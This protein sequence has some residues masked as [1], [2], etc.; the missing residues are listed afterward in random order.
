MANP[1]TVTSSTKNTQNQTVI[2]T[3]DGKH[4][5]EVNSQANPGDIKDGTTGSSTLGSAPSS[6]AD[7]FTKMLN[8]PFIIAILTFFG[9]DPKT[10]KQPAAAASGQSSTT[11][12]TPSKQVAST[13]PPPPPPPQAPANASTS[14]SSSTSAAPKK[15]AEDKNAL[16]LLSDRSSVSPEAK[17]KGV[18]NRDGLRAVADLDINDDKAWGEIKK[19][20]RQRYKDEANKM[21]NDP[22]ALL[23]METGTVTITQDHFKEY[24]TTGAVKPAP[25]SPGSAVPPQPTSQE[26]ADCMGQSNAEQAATKAK[27]KESSSSSSST[28]TSSSSST[29]TDKKPTDKVLDPKERAEIKQTWHNKHRDDKKGPDELTEASDSDVPGDIHFGT[30]YDI[31]KPG[32]VIIGDKVYF[33]EDPKTNPKAHQ[34]YQ[35]ALAVGKQWDFVSKPSEWNMSSMQKDTLGMPEGTKAWTGEKGQT[36]KNTY[37]YVTKETTMLSLGAGGKSD[38]VQTKEMASQGLIAC[39]TDKGEFYLVSKDESPRLYKEM[40]GHLKGY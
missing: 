33:D 4:Y 18:I 37:M 9:I 1:V 34:A 32:V 6:D 29:S 8:D 10:I 14:S 7:L 11:T 25:G 16:S 21:W 17:A 28:S 40:Q 38:V 3:S 30:P 24:S 22:T 31:S 12:T 26:E 35:D 36:R 5:V 19:E 15:M 39:R 23:A 2:E 27:A 20:D 13:P